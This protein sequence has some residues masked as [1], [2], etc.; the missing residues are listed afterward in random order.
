MRCGCTQVGAHL[1]P[2]QL[3]A[4][5]P[6]FCLPCTPQVGPDDLRMNALAELVT[7]IGKRDAFH[8]LRTVE[9]LG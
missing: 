2:A 9:Q 1:L 6:F 5:S 4:L 3:A 7:Q 8:Q